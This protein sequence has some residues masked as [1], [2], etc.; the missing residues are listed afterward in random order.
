MRE[1]ISLLLSILVLASWWKIFVDCYDEAGWKSLIPF[2]NV[3]IIS[4]KTFGKGWYWLIAIIPIVGWVY[5]I[6]FYIKS[7]KALELGAGMMI[8]CFFLPFIGY[9][10]VAFTDKCEYMGVQD[11]IF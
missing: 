8:L 9:P 6:Y 5:G 1:I 7:M 10:L 11:H 3:W 4:E 2:Y